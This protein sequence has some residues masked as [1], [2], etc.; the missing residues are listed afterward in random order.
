MHNLLYRIRQPRTQVMIL[1]V[2]LCDNTYLISGRLTMSVYKKSNKRAFSVQ[3]INLI[4]RLLV[5]VL[6]YLTTV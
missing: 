5:A 4:K 6:L 2:A 3:V 1:G